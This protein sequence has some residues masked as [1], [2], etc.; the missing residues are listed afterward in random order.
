MAGPAGRRSEAEWLELARRATGLA[1]LFGLGAH[2]LTIKD[3]LLTG[4]DLHYKHRSLARFRL[5]SCL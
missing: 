4:L 2:K 5:T 3:G 1:G